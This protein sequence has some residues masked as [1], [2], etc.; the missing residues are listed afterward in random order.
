MLTIENINKIWRRDV[1]DWRISKIETQT[2]AYLFQLNQANRRHRKHQI[3]INLERTPMGGGDVLLYEL[4]CWDMQD[5]GQPLPHATPLRLMLDMTELKTHSGNEVM[6]AL[7]R[8]ITKKEKGY[9]MYNNVLMDYT[10]VKLESL[11]DM[12]KFTDVLKTQLETFNQAI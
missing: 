11:K 2:T 12:R 6:F 8:D 10:I 3:Q 1:G 9:R 7:Y 4:W 5:N